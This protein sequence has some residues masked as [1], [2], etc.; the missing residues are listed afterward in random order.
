MAKRLTRIDGGG[1]C[2]DGRTCPSFQAINDEAAYV[3]QGERV[4]DPSILAE[5]HL[6]PDE[7]AVKIPAALVH[8]VVRNAGRG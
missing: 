6:G 3:V 7:T 2:P 1:D 4:T 5:L 8:E